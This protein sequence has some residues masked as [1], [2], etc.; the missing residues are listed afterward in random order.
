MKTKI[1]A[2]AK[3]KT[4]RENANLTQEGFVG[5]LNITQQKPVSLSLVQKWEQGNKPINPYLVLEIAK[6]FQV[7]PAYFIE[8][9]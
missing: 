9:R 8:R 7:Q 3:L 2:T 5:L 1:Y 6:L 4:L